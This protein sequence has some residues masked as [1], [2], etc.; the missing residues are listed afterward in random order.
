MGIYKDSEEKINLVLNKFRG[1][2]M[3]AYSLKRIIMRS[4]LSQIDHSSPAYFYAHLL[5]AK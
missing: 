3:I 4:S 2:L 1:E 5:W